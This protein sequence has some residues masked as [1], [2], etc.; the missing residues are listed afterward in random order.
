MEMPVCAL[1][2]KVYWVIND[3]LQ[4]VQMAS[5]G[6]SVWA[7][8]LSC[9]LLFSFVPRLLPILSFVFTFLYLLAL[10]GLIC[11]LSGAFSLSILALLCPSVLVSGYDDLLSLN[12]IVCACTSGCASVWTMPS[13]WHGWLSVCSRMSSNVSICLPLESWF[14]RC[15]FIVIDTTFMCFAI[16]C[17]QPFSLCHL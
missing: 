6:I 14:L 8:L 2:M 15:C 4:C 9:I 1:N 11:M 12:G 5:S 13:P 16:S 7:R 10:T 17:D 3:F